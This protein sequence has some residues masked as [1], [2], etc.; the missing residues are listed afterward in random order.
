M[1]AA[2]TSGKT[3]LAAESGLVD[4]DLVDDRALTEKTADRLAHTPIASQVAKLIAAANPPFALGLFGPWGSGKSSFFELLRREIAVSG[5]EAKIV[6]YDAWAFAGE[7]L[8]RNFISSVSTELGFPDD[9]TNDRFHSGLYES[10]R[11]VKFD[12]EALARSFP[13]RYTVRLGLFAGAFVATFSLLISL[14]GRQDVIAALLAAVGPIVTASL[15]VAA[16]TG[17][18]QSVLAQGKVDVEQAP[19][20]PELFKKRFTELVTKA[21]KGTPDRLVVFV[22]ELDRCHPKDMIAVLTGMRTFFDVPGCVFVVAADREVIEHALAEQL[23]TMPS[24]PDEPY[25]STAGAFLDK[26]FQHQIALPPVR[27]QR[28]GSLALSLVAD[29]DVGIWAELRTGNGPSISQVMLALVPSHVVSPRRVKVL[30]NN[31]ATTARIAQ[32]RGLN[33]RLRATEIARLTV[34][35]T[36]FPAVAEDLE[37]E[38]RLLHALVERPGDS[39]G[40]LKEM[41]D[42]YPLAASATTTAAPMT[43][44]DEAI[45]D[46]GDRPRITVA[47][48]D[49]LYR[50]LRRTRDIPYPKRD[51]IFLESAS[52]PVD[53]TDVE[54]GDFIESAATEDPETIA[55]RLQGVTDEERQKATRLI[56]GV[57][58]SDLIDEE[59]T[60]AMSALETVASDLQEFPDAV[61]TALVDAI[62]FYRNEVEVPAELL[63]PM[64]EIASRLDP[65]P[66]WMAELLADPGLFATASNTKRV[67]LIANRL[68]LTQRNTVWE[69]V[70]GHVGADYSVLIDLVSR[71]PED[72]AVELIDHEAVAAALDTRL[73]AQETAEPELATQEALDLVVATRARSPRSQLLEL[74]ALWAL[75]TTGVETA[76]DVVSAQQAETCTL[77]DSDILIPF[78]L[79]GVVVA[80]PGTWDAWIGSIPEDAVLP[81]HDASKADSREVLTATAE[82]IART[83]EEGGATAF[84]GVVP[85]LVALAAAATAAQVEAVVV[86][87]VTQALDK[88]SADLDA[89]HALLSAVL[90]LRPLQGASSSLETLATDDLVRVVSTKPTNEAF[91]LP[92]N[93]GSTLSGA[94]L[95]RIAIA[96]AA[97]PVVA[98]ATARTKLIATVWLV[99]AVIATNRVSSVEIP[100]DEVQALIAGGD[101]WLP[102][103]WFRARPSFAEGK[104][105]LFETAEQFVIPVIDSVGFW[106]NQLSQQERTS[107]LLE[108][109]GRKRNRSRWVAVIAP[110]GLND[111]AFVEEVGRRIESS[112]LGEDR[113][114]LARNIQVLRPA[115][116]RGQRAVATLVLKRLEADTKLD[117]E[118]ARTLLPALGDSHKSAG[119]LNEAIRAS[120]AA[121]R[122]KLDQN[123]RDAMKAAKL[124]PPRGKRFPRFRGK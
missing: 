59:R 36:E 101:K 112:P 21:T 49:Q 97:T 5:G 17:I 124:D 37:K 13:F 120:V 121:G 31:F 71:L 92:T 81:E 6:R 1:K 116:P 46:P 99:S 29:R 73:S 63:P 25:Y 74:S 44:P 66:P 72:E 52:A 114:S 105:M 47:L 3:L 95:E 78:V 34:L 118:I 89:R 38:P 14:F 70:A 109:I 58:T 104:R 88:P 107:L 12:P 42:R 93:I 18:V 27:Q 103:A 82:L 54:L 122:L 60:N 24:R 10:K 106:A 43:A 23:P 80:D 64:L 20:S 50:Y 28:L 8:Q 61:R 4:A 111:Q 119:K 45:V 110:L 123:D 113:Q 30:L 117:A 26:V 68:T 69:H 22:D 62:G 51:L 65:T 77:G 2:S 83:D 90:G 57:V 39:R 41:L 9:G 35:R 98:P 33:W 76:L 115:D 96:T 48:L 32:A 55:P 86:P 19:P 11:S 84:L 15:V 79:E 56:A 100:F 94:N 102:N 91:L 75:L 40:R 67:A 16:L 87:A 85:R 53:L 7:S 108:W